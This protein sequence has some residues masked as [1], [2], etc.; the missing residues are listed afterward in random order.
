MLIL[1][2]KTKKEYLISPS[3]LNTLTQTKSKCK[4]FKFNDIRERIISCNLSIGVLMLLLF[5]ILAK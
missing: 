4:V 1:V 3:D 5:N 2:L